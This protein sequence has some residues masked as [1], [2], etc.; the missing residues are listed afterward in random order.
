MPV[1]CF[2][3]SSLLATASASLHHPELGEYRSKL[4]WPISRIV[5]V[6][7]TGWTFNG[8][9]Y[10]KAAQPK[11]GQKRISKRYGNKEGTVSILEVPYRFALIRSETNLMLAN[12]QALRNC[13]TLLRS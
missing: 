11:T 9:K 8:N 13:E 1:S 4:Q 7:P 10:S 2:K 6:K 5:A 12:I 3:L